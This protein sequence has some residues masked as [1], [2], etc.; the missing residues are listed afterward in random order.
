MNYKHPNAI[1]CIQEHW[2][3]NFQINELYAILPG[4]KWAIKCI[5]DTDPISPLYR[6]RGHTGVACIWSPDLDSHI[7]QL[8]DGSDRV[9]VLKIQSLDQAFILI[10]AYLPTDGTRTGTSYIDIIEEVMQKYSHKYNLIL[11]GDEWRRH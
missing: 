7:Q 10:N 5:D 1:I 8:L 11:L 3:Y 6:P 2:L 4:C 9:L